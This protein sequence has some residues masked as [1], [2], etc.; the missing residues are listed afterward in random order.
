MERREF[1]WRRRKAFDRLE[2]LV[3]STTAVSVT[4]TLVCALYVFTEMDALVLFLVSVIVG[5]S[6]T[7][8]ANSAMSDFYRRYVS[9]TEKGNSRPV[10]RQ[11]R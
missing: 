1:E 7:L 5:G 3:T 8:L 6:A 10:R 11:D 2:T 4:G 9:G